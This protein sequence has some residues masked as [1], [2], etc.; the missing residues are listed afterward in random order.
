MALRALLATALPLACLLLLTRLPL[1]KLQGSTMIG[2]SSSSVPMPAH[3]VVACLDYSVL[4]LPDPADPS[5]STLLSPLFPPDPYDPEGVKWAQMVESNIDQIISESQESDVSCIDDVSIPM[6]GAARAIALRLPAWR[7][8]WRD[9]SGSATYELL[10][11]YL[12]AYGC[13]LQA[14]SHLIGEQI[15]NARRLPPPASSSVMNRPPPSYD[16]YIR[17]TPQ[18][19]ENETIDMQTN[20]EALQRSLALLMGINRFSPLNNAFTCID[21]ASKDLRNVLGLVGNTST[22]M[23]GRTWDVRGMLRKF[24]IPKD[25]NGE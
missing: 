2:G 9:R 20:R 1:G 12:E 23:P 4:Q 6:P 14:K 25:S 8:A 7:Y 10:L 24:E 5:G 21:R 13:T 17:D 3:G 15:Q 19:T 16:V 11:D 18:W 22:C